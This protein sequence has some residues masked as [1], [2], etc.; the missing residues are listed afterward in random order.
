MANAVNEALIRDVIG[1]LGGEAPAAPAAGEDKG[2]CGCSGKSGGKDFGVF[3]NANDAC[4]AAAG[5]FLQLREQGVEARRKIIEIVKG[6]CEA[7]ADEWGRIEL[8]ESKIGRL[9]HKIEKLHIILSL[10]HI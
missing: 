8:E 1:R 5:A 3:Q 7:N 4:D 2:S 10:I 9:D 6:M